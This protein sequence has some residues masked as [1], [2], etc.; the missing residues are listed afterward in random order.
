MGKPTIRSHEW[1]HVPNVCMW[2]FFESAVNKHVEEAIPP[3]DPN[4][5]QESKQ[6]KSA[7]NKSAGRPKSVEKNAT[8]LKQI[9]V[10]LTEGENIKPDRLPGNARDLHDACKRVAKEKLKKN[11]FSI[12]LSTFKEWLRASGYGFGNGRTPSIEAKYWT[13]LC[14]KN[15]VKIDSAIFT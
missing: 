14:V 1:L 10:I 5:K 4:T 11:M 12:S 6:L 15:I 8:I 9:I 3:F 13:S 7:I 2:K